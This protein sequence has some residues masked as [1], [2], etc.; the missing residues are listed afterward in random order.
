[1]HPGHQAFNGYPDDR[2]GN[3]YLPPETHDL[4]VPRAGKR[5]PQPEKDE[6]EKRDF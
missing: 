4:V 6:N 3:K 1:M 5:R 2:H